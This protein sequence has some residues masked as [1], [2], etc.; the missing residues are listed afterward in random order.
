MELSNLKLQRCQKSFGFFLEKRQ[1]FV[2]LTPCTARKLLRLRCR[3]LNLGLMM[4]TNPSIVLLYLAHCFGLFQDFRSLNFNADCRKLIDSSPII[5][6]RYTSAPPHQV[7]LFVPR[8]YKSNYRLC[9]R[10]DFVALCKLSPRGSTIIFRQLPT[11]PTRDRYQPNEQ[12]YFSYHLPAQK[13]QID[14]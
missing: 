14:G 10:V 3:D 12:Q 13:K 5:P 9:G 2:Q 4:V 6:T 11:P 8:R 1:K 7:L